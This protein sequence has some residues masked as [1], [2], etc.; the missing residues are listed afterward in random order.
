MTIARHI[1][2]GDL[3]KEALLGGALRRTAIRGDSSMVV[4]NWIEPNHPPL[5]DHSHPFDQLAFILKGEMA[6][7]IENTWYRLR[8]GDVLS[9]PADV[10]H[11]GHVVGSQT[12]LNVD[13]FGIARP[14]F[15]HLTDWQLNSENNTPPE[16]LRK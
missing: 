11:G 2:I 15:L 3:P 6:M 14:D 9:I 5:A 7:H 8:A 16:E 4:Y 1:T 10:V 13:V 12:V